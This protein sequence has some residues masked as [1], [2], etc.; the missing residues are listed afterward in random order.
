M[1]RIGN[2]VDLEKRCKMSIWLQTF[3]SI[4]PRASPVK[5]YHLAEKSEKDAVSNLSPKAKM[6]SPVEP[7]MKP[8]LMRLFAVH[9]AAREA[10][11]REIGVGFTSQSKIEWLSRGGSDA[12]FGVQIFASLHL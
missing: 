6:W 10:V 3:A 11:L 5:F 4:Q 7:M 1:Q 9:A 8:I 2:L 12:I